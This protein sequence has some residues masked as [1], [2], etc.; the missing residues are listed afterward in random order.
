MSNELKAAQMRPMT[1]DSN[2]FYGHG[3]VLR[4]YAGLPLGP[5]RGRVQHGWAPV[6][7]E[8]DELVKRG[9]PVYVW[10]ERDAVELRRDCPSANPIMMGAPYLYTESRDAV[11]ERKG[12]VSFPHHSLN[13]NVLSDTSRWHAYAHDFYA[14]AKAEGL[15]P[16][17]VCLHIRDFERAGVVK[18]LKDSGVHV[19]MCGDAMNPFFLKR[20]DNIALRHA[21]ATS[22]RVSTAIFYC[23]F[24]GMPCV[25]RGDPMRCDPPDIHEEATG[26]VDWIRE[27][28]P[29]LLQ[30]GE[31]QLLAA[32]QLGRVNMRKP[33]ELAAM[34]HVLPR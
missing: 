17:T 21:A 15:L 5:I 9:E 30:L 2:E 4:A 28:Y 3:H 11:P 14:W 18:A 19:D 23:L 34:L 16:A 13:R 29:S 22:N 25:V 6:G 32:R 24:M 12:V 7:F 31:N 20:F 8:S 10:A 1:C 26:A 33:H 27:H